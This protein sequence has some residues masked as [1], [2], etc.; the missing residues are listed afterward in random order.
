MVQRFSEKGWRL[1]IV[2]DE[3]IPHEDKLSN[4]RWRELRDRYHDRRPYY[5]GLVA[6]EA[7]DDLGRVGTLGVGGG[8]KFVIFDGKL[9]VKFFQGQDFMHELGHCLIDGAATNPKAAH[10]L[11]HPEEFDDGVH[12]PYNCVMN[13]AKNLGVG[14]LLSQWWEFNFDPR[15]WGAVRGRWQY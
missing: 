7:A 10:L 11:D 15:C 8:D 9:A 2:V 13:Y 12:C 3:T 14:E 1:H 5:W 4:A 6:H